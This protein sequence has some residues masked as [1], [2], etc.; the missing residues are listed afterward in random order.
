MGERYTAGTFKG[1]YSVIDT[2]STIREV[3]A[4]CGVKAHATRI[5]AALN[6]VEQL[7]A[8]RQA[9]LDVVNL[10]G[11]Q[12]LHTALDDIGWPKGER[13]G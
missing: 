4:R 3:I 8:E 12:T 5:I 10:Y 1:D 11:D 13:D 2:D 7:R 9:V 6:E